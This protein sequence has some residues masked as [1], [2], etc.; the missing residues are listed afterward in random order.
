MQM[1]T[2]TATPVDTK[3]A[4]TAGAV[5]AA[6]GSAVDTKTAG[7]GG[8]GGSAVTSIP[9]VVG[10]KDFDPVSVGLSPDFILTN[11]SKLKGYVSMRYRSFVFSY[12][13]LIHC[14]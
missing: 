1:A 5:T 11:H 8:S 3:T 2:A 4:S 10:D 14:R 6:A 12:R 13:V 7:S 9:P